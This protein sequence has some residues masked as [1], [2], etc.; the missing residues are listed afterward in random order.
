MANPLRYTYPA[1]NIAKIG[2]C[3]LTTGTQAAGV[4]PRDYL[5]GRL[6]DDDPAHP[7]KTDTTTFRIL[8]DFGSALTAVLVALIHHNLA[9][10]LTNVKFAMGST[11]ATTDFSRSFVI[12]AYH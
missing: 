6:L 11:T 2:T 12:P 7:F 10:N 4:T 1:D 9:H 3:T 8:W 5:P